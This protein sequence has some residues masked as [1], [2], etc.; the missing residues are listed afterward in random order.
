MPLTKHISKRCVISM[1]TWCVTKTITTI[2]LGTKHFPI[3]ATRT[4]HKPKW[5][6]CKHITPSYAPA[7]FAFGP[8][9][10]YPPSQDSY[11]SIIPANTPTLEGGIHETPC[12]IPVRSLWRISLCRRIP[13][14]VSAPIGWNRCHGVTG[15]RN[16]WVTVGVWSVRISVTQGCRH[17]L[18]WVRPTNNPAGFFGYPPIPIRPLPKKTTANP[19]P[20]LPQ[21]YL[22]RWFSFLCRGQH[23]LR[24]RITHPSTRGKS[25]ILES[26]GTETDRH[27]VHE[28][29][30][31]DHTHLCQSV[32]KDW[33]HP[34]GS[35]Y[36]A[37]VL[38]VLDRIHPSHFNTTCLS[39]HIILSK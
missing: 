16:Y 33:R 21:S 30:Q 25:A 5:T 1:N 10:K 8:S 12:R 13:M 11:Q 34:Q 28:S 24:L 4:L 35:V 29:H 22:Y 9:T 37:A 18:V 3:H 14:S 39:P 27:Y 2:P 32:G 19:N 15:W 31:A 36:L 23:I 26:R 6:R 38:F 7:A 17:R 20:N